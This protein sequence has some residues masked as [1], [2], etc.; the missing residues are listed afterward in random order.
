V[1]NCLYQKK[2]GKKESAVMMLVSEGPVWE[3]WPGKIL[4][5]LAATLVI[6]NTVET[7]GNII[8]FFHC[9]GAYTARRN[10][11]F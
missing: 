2:N 6:L 10:L 9:T 5:T 11:L 8:L 1:A 4:L 7:L 3:L